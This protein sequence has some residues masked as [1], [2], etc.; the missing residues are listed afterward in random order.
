MEKEQEKK[1]PRATKENAQYVTK[2]EAEIAQMTDDIQQLKAR[3]ELL[4]YEGQ[5]DWQNY[6]FTDPETGKVGLMDI[7]G[8]VLIPARYDAIPMPESFLMMHEYIHA[9]QK[10]DKFALM[11]ADGSGEELT[12]FK[13]DYIVRYPFS[14]VFIAY[15]GNDNKHFGLLWPNGKPLVPNI[16]TGISDMPIN[17]V[18]KLASDGKYGL[19]CLDNMQ[20]VMPEYDAVDIEIDEFVVFHK[21]DQKF[22]IDFDGN[23]VPCEEVDSD[24]YDGDYDFLNANVD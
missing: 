18:V 14:S 13:Y 21:G 10:D 6:E 16:L 22:Y 4:S 17:G 7:E 1:L 9:V 2:R 20:I 8:K 15:W 19:F 24:D 3:S 11:R 23:A 12:E 5:Y